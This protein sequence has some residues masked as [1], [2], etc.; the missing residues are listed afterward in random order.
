MRLTGLIV[1]LAA[2]AW[3]Q[4]LVEHAA[5]AA[6]GSAGGVAGK[7]VSDGVTKIF[8]K[9]NQRASKAA[10]APRPTASAPLMEVGPGVPK[11]KVPPPPPPVHHAAVRR[12]PLP[13]RAPAPVSP[14]VLEAPPAPAPP[15][16]P[17]TAAELNQIQPGA[18]REDVLK[19]GTPSSRIMMFEDGHLLEIYRYLAKQTNVGS[20]RLTD[21]VVSNVS[22]GR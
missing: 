16:P 19:L 22:V 12:V 13:M 9:V 10:E 14:P 2:T 20:V 8:G 21:G 11:S 1:L 15:P 6:G 3:S 7:K 17:V 4:T 5:A 18:T